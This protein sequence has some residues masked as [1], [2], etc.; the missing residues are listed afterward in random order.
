MALVDERTV[1]ELQR[2]LNVGQTGA[3]LTKDA[4]EKIIRALDDC[5]YGLSDLG[6]V[7]AVERTA[8]RRDV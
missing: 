7:V 3:L 4:R 8:R 1:R 6:D 2:S 5:S